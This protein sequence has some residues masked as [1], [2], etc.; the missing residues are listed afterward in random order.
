MESAFSHETGQRCTSQLCVDASH[1]LDMCPGV[2][3]GV[4]G[5]RVGAVREYFEIVTDGIASSSSSP[6]SSSTGTSKVLTAVPT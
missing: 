5:D 6:R 3:S 2:C 1:H 4:A